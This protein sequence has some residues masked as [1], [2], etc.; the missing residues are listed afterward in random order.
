MIVLGVIGIF[1]VGGVIM[2][3]DR[4]SGVEVFDD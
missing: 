2:F 1:I 3:K 4:D